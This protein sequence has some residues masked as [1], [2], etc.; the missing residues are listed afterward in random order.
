MSCGIVTIIRVQVDY[1]LVL[2]SLFISISP[3]DAK[4]TSL[5]SLLDLKYMFIEA[6]TKVASVLS[7]DNPQKIK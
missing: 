1:S 2:F 5:I 3:L 6:K 4:V 7:D